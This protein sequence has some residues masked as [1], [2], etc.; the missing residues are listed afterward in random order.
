MHRGAAVLKVWS[1]DLE[2]S[3]FQ[4]KICV[5][6]ALGLWLRKVTLDAIWKMTHGGKVNKGRRVSSLL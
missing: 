1:K 3:L 2:T 5:R 4:L 6:P